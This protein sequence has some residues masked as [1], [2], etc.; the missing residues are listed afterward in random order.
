M[1]GPVGTPAERRWLTWDGQIMTAP[2]GAP[3]T[4]FGTY[5]RLNHAL[6]SDGYGALTQ[7]VTYCGKRAHEIPGRGPVDCPECL[8][9]QP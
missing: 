5:D 2:T 9:G 1:S 7:A 3:L 8:V 4:A 6:D